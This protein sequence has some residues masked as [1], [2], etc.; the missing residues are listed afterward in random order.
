MPLVGLLRSGLCH[1][2]LFI[3]LKAAKA[4]GLGI[5]AHV[6]AQ[7]VGRAPLRSQTCIIVFEEDP[8][9][10]RAEGSMEQIRDP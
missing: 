5:P 2:R 1:K 4:I 8:I 10:R 7:A 9:G 6:L 3:N